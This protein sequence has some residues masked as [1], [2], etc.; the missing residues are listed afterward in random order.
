MA[1]CF[2]SAI[3]INPWNVDE[4]A[5][6][7]QTALTMPMEERSLRHKPLLDYIRKYTAAFWC[8]SFLNGNPPPKRARK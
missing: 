5:R 1:G 8:A 2:S 4:V 3:T 6:A 7:I